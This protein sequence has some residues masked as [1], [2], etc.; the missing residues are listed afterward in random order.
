MHFFPPAP[1]AL[2]HLRTHGGVG[3][4]VA[5]ALCRVQGH[6]PSTQWWGPG[7]GPVW[8]DLERATGVLV[9]RPSRGHT[10]VL[11]GASVLAHNGGGCCY[12]LNFFSHRHIVSDLVAFS[13]RHRECSPCPNTRSCSGVLAH[14]GGGAPTCISG[15]TEPGACLLAIPESS[16]V[17]K[18]KRFSKSLAR[19]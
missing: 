17:K 19:F 18:K 15:G 6:S 1:F 14:P 9:C 7:A 2:Q 10:L 8:A 5:C 16:L 13:S 4:S 12:T 3:V 11:P